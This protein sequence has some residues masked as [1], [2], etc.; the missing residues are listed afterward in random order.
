MPRLSVPAPTGVAIFALLCLL[1]SLRTG[2]SPAL[3]RRIRLPASSQQP[4]RS[5]EGFQIPDLV[6][7]ADF[8]GVIL[9]TMNP[10][11]STG[12][13]LLECSALGG[14]HRHQ[15][16]PGL[17]KRLRPFVLKLVRQ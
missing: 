5:I 3:A 16:A 8:E 4:A 6:S 17:N 13:G 2:L 1:F 12:C 7:R 9:G 15:L 14:D 11:P 10:R